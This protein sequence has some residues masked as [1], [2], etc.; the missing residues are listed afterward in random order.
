MTTVPE[1]RSRMWGR[2]ALVT[3]R[4]PKRLV[5]NC[6]SA[7]IALIHGHKCVSEPLP[8]TNGKFGASETHPP[9]SRTAFTP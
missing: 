8:W 5:W 9:S 7:A 4:T 1:R 2:T 3:L 6:V